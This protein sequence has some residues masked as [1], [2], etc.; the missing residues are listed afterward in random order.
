MLLLLI[1][2]MFLH[3]MASFEV[4]MAIVKGSKDRARNSPQLSA[5]VLQKAIL[6]FYEQKKL[7]PQGLCSGVPAV[8]DWALQ[9]GVMLKKMVRASDPR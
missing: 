6:L 4:V 1:C 2:K 8:Q 7:F 5:Y 9:Q 3:S